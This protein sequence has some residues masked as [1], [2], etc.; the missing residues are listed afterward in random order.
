MDDPHVGDVLPTS[1]LTLRLQGD[2][3]SENM[4]EL[5]AYRSAKKVHFFS[6]HGVEGCSA[7]PLPP[8]LIAAK[9]S[10]SLKILCQKLNCIQTSKTSF[11][12]DQLQAKQLFCNRK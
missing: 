2:N 9:I 12:K 10:P 3:L 1:A 8:S 5:N 6:Q 4:G 7:S 11:N